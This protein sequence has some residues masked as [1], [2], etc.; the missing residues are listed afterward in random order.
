MVYVSSY[1]CVAYSEIH[2]EGISWL[3]TDAF[4]KSW[5]IQRPNGG[6]DPMSPKTPR[7]WNIMTLPTRFNAGVYLRYGLKGQF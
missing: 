7:K 3:V 1:K 2:N 5:L 4:T 6:Q